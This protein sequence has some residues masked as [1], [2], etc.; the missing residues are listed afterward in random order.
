M[1]V[2]KQ[3]L[4]MIMFQRVQLTITMIIFPSIKGRKI[5]VPHPFNLQRIV[6]YFTICSSIQCFKFEFNMRK[7]LELYTVIDDIQIHRVIG[8]RVKPNTNSEFGIN[9]FTDNYAF[10]YTIIEGEYIFLDDEEEKDSLYMIMNI[11]MN[12]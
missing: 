5:K 6:V 3:Y 1:L 8:K 12:K 10:V 7:F 11:Y 2:I 4:S 9:N